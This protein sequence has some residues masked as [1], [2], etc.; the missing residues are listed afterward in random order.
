M[1][2]SEHAVLFHSCGTKPLTVFFLHEWKMG[3]G[4][5]DA[6]ISSFACFKREG[7]FCSV[8]DISFSH[9]KDLARG[10]HC[11]TLSE[12]KSFYLCHEGELLK[13]YSFVIKVSTVRGRDTQDLCS[14]HFSHIQY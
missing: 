8:I 14:R 4:E 7:C 10:S 3:F 1:L 6:C 12:S 5:G 2:P 11:E 9:K 13:V